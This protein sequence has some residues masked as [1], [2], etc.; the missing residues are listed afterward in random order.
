MSVFRNTY[1]IVIGN[2]YGIVRKYLYAIM[3]TQYT[4]LHIL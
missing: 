2:I 4:L 3:V 1:F